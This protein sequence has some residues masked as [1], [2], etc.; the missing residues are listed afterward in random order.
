MREL[1]ATTYVEIT[2]KAMIGTVVFFHMLFAQKSAN[3]RGPESEDRYWNA[4][5]TK[6][7]RSTTSNFK[8]SIKFLAKN[9]D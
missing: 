1:V 4:L 9:L 3:L 7:R 6:S 2:L 8:S 5:T